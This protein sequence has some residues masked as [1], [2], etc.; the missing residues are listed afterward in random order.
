MPEEA[1][2]I[3]I[4]DA[5]ERALDQWHAD[6]VFVGD[7]ESMVDDFVQKAIGEWRETPSEKL[8]VEVSAS[9]ADTISG[10]VLNAFADWHSGGDVDADEMSS[11]AEEF[12]LSAVEEWKT[13]H[14]FG[15]DDQAAP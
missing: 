14:G 3:T 7:M 2:F 5:V 9:D 10:S 6:G 13:S 1:K 4:T 11:M 12:A 8:P 15:E